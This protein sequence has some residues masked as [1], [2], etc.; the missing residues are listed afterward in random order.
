MSSVL[1]VHGSETVLTFLLRA[2]TTRGDTEHGQSV[3]HRLGW[4]RVCPAVQTRAWVGREGGTPEDGGCL[5]TC[6][7]AELPGGGGSELG[8]GGIICQDGHIEHS[9]FKELFI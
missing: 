4:P 8:Y 3:A 1:P 5:S 9:S 6:F 2:G 7:I